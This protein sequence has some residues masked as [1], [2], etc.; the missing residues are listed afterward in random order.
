MSRRACSRGCDHQPFKVLDEAGQLRLFRAKHGPGR[1]IEPVRLKIG[2][3]EAAYSLLNP[4]VFEV[5]YNVVRP[6]QHTP[7]QTE[8][9]QHWVKISEAV[10]QHPI[11]F[12]P[13]LCPRI[14]A[15]DIHAG[16]DVCH[17]RKM[18]GD[19]LKLLDLYLHIEQEQFGFVAERPRSCFDSRGRRRLPCNLSL[20]LP[21]QPRIPAMTS[22]ASNRLCPLK[23]FAARETFIR[24]TWFPGHGAGN[25]PDLLLVNGPP[26]TC[27]VGPPNGESDLVTR[28]SISYEL[29]HLYLWDLRNNLFSSRRVPASPHLNHSRRTLLH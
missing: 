27:G 11:H 29:S 1:L 3:I 12:G 2:A 5:A 8:H 21:L 14:L 23:A 7:I 10:I 18:K 28:L 17:G 6:E 4:A 24:E 19:P 26:H 22:M 13:I 16:H 25:P 20:S 9:G 15:R